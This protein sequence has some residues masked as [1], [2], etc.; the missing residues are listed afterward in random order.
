VSTR[1]AWLCRA[2][3]IG[4]IAMAAVAPFVR[5]QST[6]ASPG[7][8]SAGDA[9]RGRALVSAF[10]DSLPTHSGNGLRCTSCHLED[11]TRELAM[12]WFGTASRY[13]R[14]RARRGSEETLAQRVNECVARSLAGRM[15]PE[16]GRDMRDILAYLDSLG[17]LARP[18]G[19]D[20]VRLVGNVA[21]GSKVYAKS[22]ARCHGVTGAGGPMPAVWGAKSYSIGAGLARQTVLATFVHVNM[23][24][25]HKDTLTAQQAADV[26][27]FV[28]AKPRQDHPGKEHDWPKGDPPADVAYATDGARAANKPLP[29]SR[30]VLRRRVTPLPR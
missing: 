2:L 24:Y 26:A 8:A 15:L 19:P 17:T 25:D 3:S 16:D 22:C 14:Y 9:R 30:P 18:T 6:S 1:R 10:R 13:P 5:A 20:T 12:P 7:I 4:A 11:G 23:P 21:S 29:T 28:L 27:S